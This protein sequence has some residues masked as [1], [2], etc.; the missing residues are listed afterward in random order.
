[1]VTDPVQA[2]LESGPNAFNSIRGYIVAGAFTP[3]VV[4]G[5]MEIRFSQSYVSTIRIGGQFRTKSNVYTDRLMEI[6][7]VHRIQNLRLRSPA[8]LAH[9]NHT[10]LSH[11]ATPD[12]FLLAGMFV[13]L[14]AADVGFVKPRRSPEASWDDCRTLREVF[15]IQTTPFSA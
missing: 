9:P 8:K 12:V 13:S 7:R 4:N 15:A 1:V 10:G 5:A 11:C 14:L 2:A 6:A 3:C